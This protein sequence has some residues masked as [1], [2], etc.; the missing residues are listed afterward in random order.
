[1][2]NSDY[3]TLAPLTFEDEVSF[4]DHCQ[5]NIP[6]RVEE[7]E[8][9]IRNPG[10]AYPS[11]E[12]P[13][14]NSLIRKLEN[15]PEPKNPH[16]TRVD[17]A[18]GEILY[19]G[20][21]TLTQARQSPELPKSHSGIKYHL[22]LHIDNDGKGY[23]A[24]PLSDI[25]EVLRRVRFV[26]E[27][28]ELIEIT[29]PETQ[30]NAFAGSE[31]NVLAADLLR[32]SISKTRSGSIEPIGST[33]QSDQFK[34]TRAPND[35][36]IAIQ[37]P[38]G[39]GKTVVLLERI[40]R[41]AFKDPSARD[42]GLVL[43]G[44]NL[45]FLEYVENALATL[46]KK[47]VITSTV[48]NLCQWNSPYPREN[49]SIEVLKA[50]LRMQDIVDQCILDAPKILETT[51]SFEI[52]NLKIIFT[53]NDSYELIASYRDDYAHYEL[54]R[55]KAAK[56]ALRILNERFFSMWQD[57]GNEIS[58]FRGDPMKIVEETSSF[59]TMM[60]KIYPDIDPISILEILKKDPNS[61]IRHANSSLEFD[62]IENW[63]TYVIPEDFEI[64]MADVPILDYIDFRINGKT[65]KAF[66]HIA[67][68]EAQN[69]TPMQF[70]MLSRR[71]EKSTS[72]SLTGDLAQAIGAI[73]YEDW[74]SI[75]THFDEES[76]VIEA[77]LT[78][79]YR[80]PKE[81]INY[82]AKFLAKA[83]VDVGPA[84]PFLDLENALNLRVVKTSEFLEKAKKLSEDH[85]ANSESVLVVAPEA[86]LQQIHGWNLKGQGLSH[87]KALVA[88]ESK[89]LEFDVVI[90]ID[91]VGILRELNYENSRSAR[92]IYMNTTRSTKKLYM[93]GATQE[94]VLDPVEAYSNED[95]S[96]GRDYSTEDISE[97]VE[98]LE[99]EKEVSQEEFS[100]SPFSVTALCRELNIDVST[101][102]T[103]FITG[104]W[105]YC[106]STQARCVDCGTKPQHVFDK[107]KEVLDSFA[108]VC[109]RCAVIRDS[110]SYDSETVDQILM[111]L[112]ISG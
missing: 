12:E 50:S 4:L 46:G 36:I 15:L 76:E 94:Q 64:K 81:I 40:S 66:G 60:R 62:D 96:D 2:S 35:K 20:F 68:D 59:K 58:R 80:V 10:G 74:E 98:P 89:G 78:K 28:G 8:N 32:S 25:P 70:K 103:S 112:D 24:L 26:I 30:A 9:L 18:G 91:P 84:E 47:D 31:D 71:V 95:D 83:D 110:N 82:S 22:I 41:I 1:M 48:E 72:I 108:I 93:I 16:F 7:L 3:E 57:Q 111:E 107:Q 21:G 44:P 88:T 97:F 92:L 75:T 13:I 53:P 65:G 79:S 6:L 86:L 77:E 69:L 52:S 38:P 42:K 51:F 104:T 14:Q 56:T 11:A 19:Y 45:N 73:Y 17:L 106:G 33:I 34:I 87:F 43:I 49:D 61:F 101:T 29:E 99:E 37:G 55:E 27:N 100:D 54:V 39:S 105:K 85:L 109:E 23:R 90:V 63:L 5:Q 67:I 102:D